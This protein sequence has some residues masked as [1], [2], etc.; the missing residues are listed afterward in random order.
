[1]P[2]YLL[3]SAGVT[4]AGDPAAT[5]ANVQANPVLFRVGIASTLV[6]FV[7]VFVLIAAIVAGDR[8]TMKAV[9][10]ND[11]DIVNQTDEGGST[12]LMHAAGRGNLTAVRLLL[13]AQ[14]PVDSN[15]RRGATALIW[16]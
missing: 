7:S 6:M 14:S 9:L 12:A 16:A 4:V 5:F 15:N 13:T 2:V 3:T 11:P 1:M 10:M 8:L